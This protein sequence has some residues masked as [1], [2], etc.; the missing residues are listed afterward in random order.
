MSK[1]DS[2]LPDDPVAFIKSCVKQRKFL[3]T[4][5]VNLRLRNRFITRQSI[6][7]SVNSYRIIESYPDDKYLPSYLVLAQLNE[8]IYHI[9]LAIDLSRDNI[10]IV[11]AYR[12]NPLEW[13][14]DFTTRSRSR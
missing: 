7:N 4:Y 1:T 13:L 9:L 3:W 14:P 6:I 5:H 10:R 12:P 8:D 11:T 2:C